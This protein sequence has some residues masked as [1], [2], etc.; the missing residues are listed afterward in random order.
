MQSKQQILSFFFLGAA[1]IVGLGVLFK[2]YLPGSRIGAEKGEVKLSPE[3]SDITVSSFTQSVP[4][5]ATVSVNLKDT[6]GNPLNCQSP[7]SKARAIWL[8]PTRSFEV[9]ETKVKTI[10]SSADCQSNWVLEIETQNPGPFSI[11][12]KVLDE[13]DNFYTLPKEVYIG[14]S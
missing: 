6:P 8:L 5:K 1:L 3:L 14:F 7:A 11:L 13:K 4:Y 12:V 10:S 9:L 2:I